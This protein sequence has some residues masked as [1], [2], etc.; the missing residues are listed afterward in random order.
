MSFKASTMLKL[1]SIHVMDVS[2]AHVGADASVWTLS[3]RDRVTENAI[4]VARTHGDMC[5]GCGC[6]LHYSTHTGLHI[7]WA[8]VHVDLKTCGNSVEITKTVPCFS[9]ASA[10]AAPPGQ[11]DAVRL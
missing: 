2:Q 10:S 5:G 11:P 7:C 9:Q 6:A 1:G 8:R 4:G 3:H